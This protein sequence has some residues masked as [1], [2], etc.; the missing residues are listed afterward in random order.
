MP[1]KSE[2]RLA[3]FASVAVCAALAGCGSEQKPKAGSAT[4]YGEVLPGSASDAMIPF[5]SVRSQPPLAAHASEPDSEPAEA[6]PAQRRQAAEPAA[7]QGRP[8]ENDQPDEAP[9]NAMPN[10]E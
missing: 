10:D 3:W 1:V 4:A 8:A 5:D 2:L 6:G 9:A 7:A